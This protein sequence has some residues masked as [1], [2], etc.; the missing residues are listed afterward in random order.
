MSLF[1]SDFDVRFDSTP[2][3]KKRLSRIV[4]TSSLTKLPVVLFRIAERVR[5][6]RTPNAAGHQGVTGVKSSRSSTAA[7]TRHIGNPSTAPL[8]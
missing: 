1:K 6:R 2:L 7:A 5:L 3:L 8:C 4:A